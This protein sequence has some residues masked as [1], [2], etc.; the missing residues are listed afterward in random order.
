[1]R[2][3]K[4]MPPRPALAAEHSGVVVAIFTE[5]G[6]VDADRVRNWVRPRIGVPTMIVEGPQVSSCDDI[7]GSYQEARRCLAMMPALGIRDRAVNTAPYSVYLRLF[8]PDARDIDAFVEAVI[9]PVLDNDAERGTDLLNTVSAFAECNASTARAA[10][11]LHLHPNTVLQRL[12]RIAKLLGPT[13]REPDEFFRVQVAV[14]VHT[15]RR[16]A[17]TD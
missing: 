3:L 10:R 12:E 13:W 5:T 1:M 9:G 15:L 11:Q 14:R 16:H 7:P 6:S 17:S 4:E 2:A 8:D